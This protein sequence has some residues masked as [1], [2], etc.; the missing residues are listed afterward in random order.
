VFS[1]ATTN[2]YYQMNVTDVQSGQRKIY[3][4]YPGPPAPAVTD[5]DAFPCP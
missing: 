3:F 2:V 1:A 4:N 5:T